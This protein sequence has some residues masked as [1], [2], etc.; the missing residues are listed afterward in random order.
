MTTVFPRRRRLS[1]L[2]LFLALVVT[3]SAVAAPRLTIKENEFRYGFVPQNTTLSHPF[4]LYSTGD[5]SLK[6]LKVI[7]GCS[8]MKAPLEKDV[9]AVG[10]STR[11]EIIYDTKVVVGEVTKQ[12]RIETN[13]GKPDKFVRFIANVVRRP[14][15]TYPLTIKPY[16]LDISQFSE[17][18]RD[19]MRF[20]ITNVS[21]KPINLSLVY[22]ANEYF[23]LKLPKSVKP[24]EIVYGTIKLKPAVLGESFEKSFTF[25]VNDEQKNRYTVPVKRSLKATTAAPAA[26]ASPGSGK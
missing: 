23:D 5:D 10:D 22:S 4:W 18:K 2:T 24:H 6:I 17:K 25:E 3:V 13:E 16:K 26:V 12:P 21:D 19:T 15:S 8:C 9:L 7:P 11:L 14:D 1:G 20:S